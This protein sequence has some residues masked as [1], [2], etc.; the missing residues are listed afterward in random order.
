MWFPTEPEGLG[1]REATAASP[2]S[3]P[4][5]GNRE[6]CHRRA[7]EAGRQLTQ[8]ASASAR[9]LP[10]RLARALDCLVPAGTG[11]AIFSSQSLLERPSQAH[12]EVVF[13]QLSGQP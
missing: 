13:Y 8:G 10:L 7:G 12:P 5:P 6:R 2:G 1:T 4:E 9:P 3:G 11:Q